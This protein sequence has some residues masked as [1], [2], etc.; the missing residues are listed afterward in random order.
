M[1]GG[2]S[3]KFLIFMFFRVLDNLK[4]EQSVRGVPI[5]AAFTLSY[6]TCL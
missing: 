4:G 2:F 1:R 6:A 5:S 3:R